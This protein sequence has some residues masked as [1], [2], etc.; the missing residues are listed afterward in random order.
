MTHGFARFITTHKDS[1]KTG[2]ADAFLLTDLLDSV[3]RVKVRKNTGAD[4]GARRR[5]NFIEGSNIGITVTDDPTNEEI[6]VAIASVVGAHNVLDGSVHSD[7]LAKAVAA[8][9]M[10]IGNATPKWDILLKDTDGMVLT[11]VSG[12]PAWANLTV[13]PL[14]I[15]SRGRIEVYDYA[16]SVH[17]GGSLQHYTANRAYFSWFLVPLNC[18]V[19]RILYEITTQAGNI[20]LGIYNSA[21]TRLAST[22]SFA[23][24]AAGQQAASITEQ[25]LNAGVYILAFA[26]NNANTY[27]RYSGLIEEISLTGYQNSGYQENAFPLPA[28]ITPTY[29]TRRIWGA[30]THS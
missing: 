8:G 12:L 15:G 18:K 6:A 5:L 10:M 24:P 29:G 28:T 23:C 26:S 7:T 2:G 20:D 19:D 22:G 13:P 9:A 1:H 17:I 16:L 21:L 14:T 3:G 4:V 11:L 25:T 27:W 30:I